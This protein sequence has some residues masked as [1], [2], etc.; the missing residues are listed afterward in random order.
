L[1]VLGEYFLGEG[2]PLLR[3]FQIL[4]QVFK[5]PILDLIAALQIHGV[6]QLIQPLGSGVLDCLDFL[7]DLQTE[8]VHVDLLLAVLVVLVFTGEFDD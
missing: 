8:L 3:L 2:V 1:L 7:D 5:H 6:E 4:E